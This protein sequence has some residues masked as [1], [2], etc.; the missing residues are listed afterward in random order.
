MRPVKTQPR[1][2]CDFCSRVSTRASMERHEG[3]CWRNPDRFCPS[4][5][6]RGHVVEIHQEAY[7][8]PNM[9]L[10]GPE[11]SEKYPCPWCSQRYPNVADM[12]EG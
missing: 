12:A 8:G 2:H 1:F 9:N 6:N 5:E 11:L 10:I 7:D 4:C 3:I